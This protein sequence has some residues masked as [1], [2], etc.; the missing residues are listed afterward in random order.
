MKGYLQQ[1]FLL[2]EMLPS[3]TFLVYIWGVFYNMYF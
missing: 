1:I 2:F 3:D